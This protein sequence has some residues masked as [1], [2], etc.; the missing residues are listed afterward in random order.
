ML[1]T[2][3]SA[4][5]AVSRLQLRGADPRKTYFVGV[6]GAPEGLARISARIPKSHVV[7]AVLDDCLDKNAMIVPGLGDFGDRYF[8]NVPPTPSKH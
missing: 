2:G 7:L 1:A 5:S 4:A 6:I 3:G 8:G